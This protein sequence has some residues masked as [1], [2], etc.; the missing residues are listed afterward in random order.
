[1]KHRFLVLIL[2]SSLLRGQEVPPKASNAFQRIPDGANLRDVT[3][4]SYGADRQPISLLTAQLLIKDS[5]TLLKGE[6]L[7]L[8][9]FGPTGE[10]THKLAIA[11]GVLNV[12]SQ[13]LDSS[14]EVLVVAENKQFALW[15]AGGVFDLQKQ[16]GLIKGPVKTAFSSKSSPRTP[17]IPLSFLLRPLNLL[18][19]APPPPLSVSEKLRFE[20]TLAE[21]SSP[22]A[23]PITSWADSQKAGQTLKSAAENYLTEIGE[24]GRLISA[25]APADEA[26][27]AAPLADQSQPLISQKEL[28]ELLSPAADRL[29]I[30]TDQGLYFD[31]TKGH[32][33]YLGNVILRSEGLIL[34]CREDLRIL[35]EVAKN[36]PELESDGPFGDFQGIENL[37]QVIAKGQVEVKGTNKQGQPMG[38]RAENAVYNAA[39]DQLIL[40]GGDLIFRN[41]DTI[42]FS[43]DP[44]AYVTIN[45]RAQT[46]RLDGNWRAGVPTQDLT[47]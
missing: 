22:P 13:R 11:K 30:E 27:E 19:A 45:P 16:K 15:G 8:R 23:S 21:T 12:S 35:F 5:E 37:K 1:M 40:R 33:V 36:D 18:V 6:G 42:A 26:L 10:V 9:L 14:E 31:A 24:Q 3:L 7:A 38:G 47:P 28:T 41:G 32:L 44:E 17:V 20:R 34:K 4:P 43:N 39:T 25:P 46:A 29:L 2:L